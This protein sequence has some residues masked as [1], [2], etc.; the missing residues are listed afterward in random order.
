MGHWV[1]CFLMICLNALTW[2]KTKE[3]HHSFKTLHRCMG[4]L[5]IAGFLLMS[6]STPVQLHYSSDKLQS[7]SQCKQAAKGIKLSWSPSKNPALQKNVLCLH[8]FSSSWSEQGLN[9][10]NST[11]YN[12]KFW[13]GGCAAV[14]AGAVVSGLRAV[15]P[16]V[17]K[18]CEAD[19]FFH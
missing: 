6:S 9:P 12:R 17:A 5:P 8:W 13:G 10:D 19:T 11:R 16:A 4:K 15:R 3:K 7:K 14:I 1:N 18:A 2:L